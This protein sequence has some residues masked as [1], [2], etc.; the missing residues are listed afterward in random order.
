MT[1][2]QFVAARLQENDPKSIEEAYKASPG[3]PLV[4]AALAKRT[5]YE[6][7]GEARFYIQVAL[8]YARLAGAPEQI[9][10]VQAMAKSLFPEAPE[11]N[12]PEPGAKL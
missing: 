12:G 8:R 7:K 1:V 4:L 3:N 9:A 2:P 10:Q 6:D 5:F 11:F